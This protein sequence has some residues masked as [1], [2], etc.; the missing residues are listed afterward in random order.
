L[1]P[2]AAVLDARIQI[3]GEKF[4]E[5]QTSSEWQAPPPPER[6]EQ[7]EPAQMSEAATLGNIFFEPGNTFED[8]R[9][10]PRFI[11]ATVIMILVVTAF[12]AFFI[13]KVG[14]ENLVRQRMESNSR[15][16][17]LP[18]DQKAQIIRQQTGPIWKAV[19]YAVPP[20][21]VIAI[22]FLG[23]LLY[24]GASNAFGGSSGYLQNVSVWTYS[25]FPPIFISMLANIV[26]LIFKSVDDIDL[27]TSQ[28]GLLR[29]NPSMFIDAK[30]QPALSAVLSTFDLFSIWGWILAA[31]GLR[32]VCK[33]TA[34]SAWAI[35]LIFALLSMVVRVLFASL[36]G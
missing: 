20:V 29:A 24:W 8:L 2:W 30:A 33:L 17:Q 32:I 36:F 19:S 11:L 9:R 23:G 7:G 4:M 14:F 22:V 13:S 6:I 21:I 18:E 15:V 28:S 26:I 10:K 25:S 35:V 16:Q 27:T 1:S 12:N 5:E 3:T 34:G 31:I